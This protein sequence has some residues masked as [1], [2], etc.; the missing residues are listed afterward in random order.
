MRLMHVS[1]SASRIN[2]ADYF[3]A[4]ELK[5]CICHF[6]VADTPFQFQGCEIYWNKCLHIAEKIELTQ[7][8]IHNIWAITLNYIN[9]PLEMLRAS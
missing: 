2:N 6:S 1:S 9:F 5:G 3:A 4:L 7:C 8:C